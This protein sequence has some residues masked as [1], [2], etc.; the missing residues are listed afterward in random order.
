[1]TANNGK[2]FLND[3]R[4]F[5]T[6]ESGANSISTS[7]EVSKVSIN[8]GSLDLKNNAQIQT[9]VR[10]AT[11]NNDGSVTPAGNG[12]A[13]T[14][15]INV[16]GAVTL[17]GIETQVNSRLEQEAIGTGGDIEINS[18]SLDLKN[19]AQVNS[20]TF[21]IGKGG[22][23]DITT[24]S[25]SLDN[26]AQ[27][28]TQTSGF[29]LTNQ[30][31]EITLA[32]AG[33]I[34]V[35]VTDKLEVLG[36]SQ[37]RSDTFGQG[38]GGNV[39]VNAENAIVSFDGILRDSQGNPILNNNN[40]IP[41]AIGSELGSISA[42]FT[43][44][45]KAG[46]ISILNA[47]E[48]SLTNGAR[49][50]SSTFGS[51]NAGTITLEAK[52][53]VSLERNSSVT[54]VIG[55]GGKGSNNPL[56]NES[57]FN[58]IE[59]K[60]EFPSGTI[61]INAGQLSLKDDSVIDVSTDAEGNAGFVLVQAK[62]V[63]SLSNNSAIRNT[64]GDKEQAGNA[65]LIGLIAN[66]LS[67]DSG[68]K[69]TTQT[70][71]KGNAGLV[72]VQTN[73]DVSLTGNETGIFSTVGNK[74]ESGENIFGIEIQARSLFL[75]E[76]AQINTSTSGKGNA[77][78]INV[79]AIEDVSLAG[80]NGTGIFS[81]VEKDAV[82]QGG[83]IVISQEEPDVLNNN[84][85]IP[86]RVSLEGG[87]QINSSTLGKGS[88]GSITVKAIEDVSLTD[89][90]TGIFSTAEET[91]EGFAGNIDID[92]KRVFIGNGAEIKVD[93]NS[94]WI[95][96]TGSNAKAGS[97]FLVG[98]R[99]TLDDG[100]ITAAT[101]VIDGGDITLNVKDLFLLRNNSLVSATAGQEGGDG[102]GG[103][104]TINA[105]D[106]FVVA[107][108]DKNSNNG[109][110]IVAK[111]SEGKGGA[112]NIN[113]L[114]RFGFSESTSQNGNGTND[115]DASSDSGDPGEVTLNTPDVDPASGL[116]SL[117]ENPIDPSKQIDQGCAAFNEDTASEFKVTGRG[118][119][120]PSP[121]QP[122]SSDAVWEDI[123]TTA[124]NP[125]K[126]T[127]NNTAKT[128]KQEANKITPAS[129]WVFN[130]NGEVTLISS[131]SKATSEKL[132]FTPKSCPNR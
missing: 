67:L 49:L 42:E 118:G 73:K 64:V 37:L 65:G 109:N 77:G 130:E 90:G 97:I 30:Q 119:L 4:I 34:T 9:L 62:D 76:G 96:E 19:N 58:I 20:N 47:T 60:E 95:R 5:S 89:N 2:V 131:A 84:I 83:N 108:N 27:L 59:G 86:K 93:S 17:D 36:G 106:G 1:M 66:S 12:N 74:A 125:Q 98:D 82:G 99:L 117:P 8:A 24:G 69:I 26:R 124:A 129:G 103:N 110:D 72:L 81:K 39:T 16:R 29:A 44:V 40:F 116:N 61:F 105:P 79:G 50:S 78:D 91:S 92:P 114:G 46:D 14:I 13:G 18:M 6:I 53:S 94:T 80:G 52:D 123:R 35:N 101:E 51:G 107:L 68:S 70:D 87:A 15:D 75:K 54:T 128:P 33:K 88:A 127:A 104:V 28:L 38:N 100:K 10:G 45:R 3:A 113:T 120:P 22:D 115:I 122:L 23:I 55:E 7:G 48:I 111:A 41:S 126:L 43:G 132:E 121:D 112:I 32:D 63:I 71:G 57:L 11:R 21:G 31:G 25:L 56:T 85:F 102:N